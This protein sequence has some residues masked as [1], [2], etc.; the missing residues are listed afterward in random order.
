MRK[1]AAGLLLSVVL[2]VSLLAVGCAGQGGVQ[3]E[4]DVQADVVEGAAGEDGLSMSEYRTGTPWM[5][6]DLAG[7]VTP[8]TP[9]DIRDDFALAVNKDDILA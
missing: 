7:V 2:S 4:S 6:I 5:C 8:D 1:S 9:T 3:Q